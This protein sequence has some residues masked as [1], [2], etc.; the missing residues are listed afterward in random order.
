MAGNVIYPND[1]F[2]ARVESFMSGVNGRIAEHFRKNLSCLEADIVSAD[3][4]N[5]YI[6]IVRTD[7]N[8][9]GKSVFCFIDKS[10]GD[11]LKAAGWK[12]PAKHARG[13]IFNPDNGMG[14]V[15]VW[16]ANYLK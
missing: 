11:V 4:G 12:A 16:G 8:G 7:A 14:A 9:N 10:N 15:S 1:A 3:P 5:R 13:N 2:N 6:K